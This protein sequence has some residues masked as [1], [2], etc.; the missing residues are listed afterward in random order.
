M[1]FNDKVVIIT[2]SGR[3]IGREIAGAFASEGARVVI[4]DLNYEEAIAAADDLAISGANTLAVQV[5]ITDPVQVQSLVDQTIKKFGK[6]DVLVNNAGVSVVRP[7]LDVTLDE[8]N[9]IIG[10]NLTGAFLCGQ[11]VGRVMVEQG[12]G[13]IVNIA[14]ISGQRGATGRAAYGASKAGLI[15]LTK[16]MAVELAPKGITVNAVAPGPVVT[17][18]SEQTHTEDTRRAYYERI[19]MLRYGLKNEIAAGVLFLASDDS[20]FVN[21]HILNVDGGFKASGLIFKD[22]S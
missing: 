18:M 19:P 8:W 2:G 6:V 5:D 4:A 9:F 16:V 3:G 20:S 13:R 7:F 11:A 1:K 15:Q 14:S 12:H 17:E 21:G 10:V 22:C